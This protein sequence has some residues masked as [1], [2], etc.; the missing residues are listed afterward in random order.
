MVISVIKFARQLLNS[1]WVY[2]CKQ[3]LGQHK[4][5]KQFQKWDILKAF[6]LLT[7]IYLMVNYLVE[8]DFLKFG[9]IIWWV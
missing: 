6:C 3:L 4:K 8:I 7:Q 1:T 9:P 5:L 2:L